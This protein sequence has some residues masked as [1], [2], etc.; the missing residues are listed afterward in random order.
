MSKVREL[1]ISLNQTLE[2]LTFT[3]GPS[4]LWA[5]VKWIF[6]HPKYLLLGAIPVVVA[7]ILLATA[8]ILL[9]VFSGALA[10]LADPLTKNLWGGA[11]L[12]IHLTLQTAIVLGGAALSYVLFT[13]VVLAIGDPIYSKIAVKVEAEAGVTMVDPPWTTGLKDALSLAGKGVLVAVGAFILGLIPL[14]GPL[15]AFAVTW[16]FIPFLVAEDLL[17]RTL[18]PRGFEG[19]H[20]TAIL[21][22]DKR[23][24]WGFG[25]LCQLLFTIPFVPIFI[26]PAAVAG[27]ALLTQELVEERSI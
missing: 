9:A 8:F 13:V 2:P 22:R 10:S 14:V 23:A 20:K 3:R 6:T 24:V 1:L 17:G 5:G 21:Q 25:T 18:V 19:A 7:G 16:I 12:A 11:A 15:L 26:M 4:T 27:A